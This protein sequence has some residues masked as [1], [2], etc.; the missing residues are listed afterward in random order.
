MLAWLYVLRY[1]FQYEIGGGWL[2][3]K[4]LG[5][6]TLRRVRLADIQEVRVV[7]AWAPRNMFSPHTVFAEAWPSFVF[8]RRAVLV[9]KTTGISRRLILSPRDPDSFVREISREISEGRDKSSL[10]A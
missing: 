8:T 3:V 10:P 7:S 5:H 4:L 1:V 9:V 2:R 6:T